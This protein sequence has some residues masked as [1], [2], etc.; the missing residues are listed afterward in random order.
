M[1]DWL[2]F[3]LPIAIFGV[4][5]AEAWKKF[6]QNRRALRAWQDAAAACGLQG[7]NTTSWSPRLTAGA[8]SLAVTIERLVNQLPRIDVR[9][10]GQDL[11]SVSI[12]REPLVRLG[13]EIEIG[14]P[15]FDRTFFIEGP[16]RP[17]LALLDAET[18]RLLTRANAEGSLQI[19][20]GTLRVEHMSDEQVPRVLPLLLHIGQ[21]LAQPVDVVRRLADNANR[22]PE[23]GV[24]LQNLR[25]LIRELPEAPETVEALRTACSDQS[26]E[27]R[28]QA[29][30]ALGSE[31]RDVLLDLA[32]SLVDDAVSAEAVATL[33]RELS[34][35]RTQAL[36]DHAL[37]K[38]LLKTA[39]ACL[40]ALGKSGDAA[41]VEP[42]L[43]R[44]LQREEADLRVAAAHALGRVGSAAAVLPLKETT[45]RF[46]L[47]QELRRATRQ[48]IAEI[49]SGLPGASPGQLSLAGTE[50]GQLSLAQAEAGQLSL[51]TDSAGQLSLGSD[52]DK[53]GED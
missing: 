26:P 11:Y 6:A 17:V 12:R 45:E 7:V 36:L 39:R 53:P 21:R 37:D 46:W 28:L 48:A 32:E 14:D 27:M 50:A 44:A 29:A 51:S 5:G 15:Q 9:F 24:R 34:F 31:G 47:D 23:A 41:A 8:G 40:E 33:D 52:D 13:R 16:M 19:T 35:E 1:P 3:L 22:D 43:I 4:R 49:Q 20:T 38:R 25:L 30:K 18:R 2:L 42:S 10:P